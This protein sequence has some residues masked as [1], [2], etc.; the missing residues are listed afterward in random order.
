MFAYFKQ[1]MNFA[2]T[3]IETSFIKSIFIY[4]FHLTNTNWVRFY[5]VGF[6]EL[7][8]FRSIWSAHMD[9]IWSYIK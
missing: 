2:V 1:I 4:K 8:L 3:E 6:D 5:S 7:A 9:A